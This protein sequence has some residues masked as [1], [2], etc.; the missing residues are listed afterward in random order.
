MKRWGVKPEVVDQYRHMLWYR[1]YDQKLQC[2]Q[3]LEEISRDILA[4]SLREMRRQI[5]IA[6]KLKK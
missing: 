5:E 4:A 2:V 1:T 3:R 6:R